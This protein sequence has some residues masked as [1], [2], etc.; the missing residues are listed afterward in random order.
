VIVPGLPAGAKFKA[1][2]STAILRVPMPRKPPKSMIAARTCPS[3]L[4]MMSTIR[5]MSSSA[6]LRTL[7]PRM[8][9][10]SWSSSTIAGVPGEG[11]GGA[12]AGGAAVAGGFSGADCPLGDGDESGVCA[13]WRV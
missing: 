9:D 6:L 8:V 3:R 12:A 10:T 1:R 7:L 13:T 2:Q 4:T 11:L 5:P